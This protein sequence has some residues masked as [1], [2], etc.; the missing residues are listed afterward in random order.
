MVLSFA[1]EDTA[2]HK[3]VLNY[4]NHYTACYIHGLYKKHSKFMQLRISRYKLVWDTKTPPS[5][6]PYTCTW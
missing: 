6:S 5:C 3:K 2:L 1:N 4:R